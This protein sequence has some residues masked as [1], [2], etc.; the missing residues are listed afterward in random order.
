M[1]YAQP[2]IYF[3]ERDAQTPLGFWDTNGSSNPSQTT[4][5]SDCKKIKQN[6]PKKK[7]KTAK[8]QKQ[9]RTYR[10]VDF[11]V[12]AD[13][14]VKLKESNKKD[15]YLDLIR[16]LKKKLWNMKVTLIVIGALRKVIKGLGQGLDWFGFFV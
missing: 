7:K 8:K 5:P 6:L 13:K 15:K 2:R 12:S 11:P 9:K 4:R 1:V 16:E 14:R 10:L 3:G